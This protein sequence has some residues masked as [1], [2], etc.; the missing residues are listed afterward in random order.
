LLPAQFLLWKR[1]RSDEKDE[2]RRSFRRFGLFLSVIFGLLLPAVAQERVEIPQ[3][4]ARP[5]Y[6]VLM[7][8]SGPGPFPAVV[9]LH[10]CG[11]LGTPTAMIGGRHLDWGQRLVDQGYIVVFPDSFGSRGLGPQCLVRDRA[12]RPSKER[13]YDAFS[14]KSWLQQRPDVIADKVSLLG[15]SNGGSSVL[16]TVAGDRKPRDGRPDFKAAVAFYPGCRQVTQSAERRDWENRLPLLILIGEVDTW[17]PAEPCRELVKLMQNGGR[18]AT[19][20]TYPNAVHE[21]DHPNRQ[22]TKRTGLAF[23]SDNT[24][25]AMV[26]TDFEARADALVRV[27]DFLS[28]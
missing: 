17:T 5:L 6:A 20:I 18:T 16:W 24:G 22:P 15:W 12:V 8:P 28:R 27:P 2:M 25:E 13:V 3:A 1:E 19:I 9:A 26:G 4:E 11:G 7:R 14:A 10:G 21:F 23:T